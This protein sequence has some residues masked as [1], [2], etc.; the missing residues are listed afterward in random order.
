VR[1]PPA[2]FLAL[3]LEA[4]ALLRD[5]PL[6]DASAVDLPNGG[7]GR[8]IADVKRLLFAS[9]RHAGGPT[10]ALFALR[11]LLGRVLDWDRPVPGPS[12]AERLSQG[13]RRRSR[14]PTGRSEGAFRLLYELEHESLLE[15]R[16]A[17]VHAFACM[18]LV[19]RTGGYRFYLGVY[20]APVSRFTPVYM[21]A[22]EPFRRFIVYPSMLGRLRAA[23]I[24]A[25]PRGRAEEEC[26][27]R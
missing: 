5:V 19:P 16:N 11:R 7:S 20:V 14:V 17:T 9:E 6:R 10:R 18:A 3:E 4:H 13:Q 24:A 21:A 25:Y 2:E 22:I 1:V 15:I 12:Y 27:A 26:P 8:T 23:W